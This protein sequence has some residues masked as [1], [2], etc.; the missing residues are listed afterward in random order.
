MRYQ[1][2]IVG[3]G[4]AGG[5]VAQEYREQGGDGSVLI[6]ARESHVPYHRPPLTKEFLRGEKPEDEVY[7]HPAEWWRDQDV[8]VRT[9]VSAT[10]LD[11]GARS[12]ALWPTARRRIPAARAGDGRHAAHPARRR[13]DPHD[14][15]LGALRREAGAAR[16]GHLGVIGG[17]FIG[18]EA[19]A[20]PG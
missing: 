10:A 19:A 2:V 20:W 16:P 5:M 3:G 13:V 9:G 8:E 4:L 14:R 1:N 7:M 18:V 12:I 6:I 17:G 15:R 11:M